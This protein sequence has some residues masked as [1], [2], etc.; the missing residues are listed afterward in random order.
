MASKSHRPVEETLS[1]SDPT[2]PPAEPEGFRTIADEQRA[3]SEEIQRMGVAAWVEAHDERTAEERQ[4]KPVA[5]VS[6]RPVDV[7]AET[8]GRR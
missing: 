8:G 1:A 2:P 7:A 6:H 4:Q 3:R 5:G